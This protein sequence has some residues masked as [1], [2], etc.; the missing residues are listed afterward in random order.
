MTRLFFAGRAETV[1][2]DAHGIALT[3]Y[4]FDDASFAGGIHALQHNQQ[5]IVAAWTCTISSCSVGIYIGRLRGSG[6][7]RTIGVQQALIAGN[8]RGTD[9]DEAFTV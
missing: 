6:R 4:M 2:V 8:L 3:E 1:V 7:M 9:M 5:T